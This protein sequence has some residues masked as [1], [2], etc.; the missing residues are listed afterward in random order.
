MLKPDDPT[1][2]KWRNVSET[3]VALL[4]KYIYV[5]VAQGMYNRLFGSGSSRLEDLA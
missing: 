5:R 1:G 3:G 4:G 2:V